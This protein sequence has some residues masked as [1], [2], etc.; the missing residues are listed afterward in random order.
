MEIEKKGNEI[1]IKHILKK[2]EMYKIIKDKKFSTFSIYK[3]PTS[4]TGVT[5]YCSDGKHVLFIDWDNCVKWLVLEDMKRLQE[6][7]NLPPFY[8]FTTK[9][10]KESGYTIGNYHGICLSKHNSKEIHDMLADTNC[11]FN[12]VTMNRRSFFKSWVLRLS[13]KGN[14]PKPKFVG[15]IG[16]NINLDEEISKAHFKLIKKIYPNI[17]HPKYSNKDCGENVKINVYETLN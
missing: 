17:K 13:K 12:Y 7:Y 3:K 5:S 16:E 9:E 11:D 2:N 15:I 14:R 4:V 8:L 1:I 10:E 6:K